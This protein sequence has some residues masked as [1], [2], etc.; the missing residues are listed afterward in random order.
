[1]TAA[2]FFHMGGY[3]F[4]VWTSYG[5]AFFV[6]VVNVVL[7]WRRER[8]LLKELARKSRRARRRE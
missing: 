2:E 3:A 5:I 6:L 8:R 4:F 1:M 7:P